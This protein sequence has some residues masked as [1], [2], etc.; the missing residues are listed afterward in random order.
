MGGEVIEQDKE[1]NNRGLMTLET[2]IQDQ[3]DRQD[4]SLS[5]ESEQEQRA[6]NEQLAQEQ[7]K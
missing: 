2:S 4:N 6:L 3:Q 1:Q 5:S 7:D